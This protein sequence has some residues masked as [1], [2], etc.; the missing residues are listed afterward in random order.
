MF[1]SGFVL[2]DVSLVMGFRELGGL[3]GGRLGSLALGF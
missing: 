1:V 2:Y 3:D